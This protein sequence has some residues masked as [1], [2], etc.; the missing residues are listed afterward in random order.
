M[1]EPLQGHNIG[2]TCRLLAIDI[3]ANT[4]LDACCESPQQRQDTCDKTLV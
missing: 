4:V 3:V 1:S 2:I